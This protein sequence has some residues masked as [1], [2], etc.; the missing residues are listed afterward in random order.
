MTLALAP[1][2]SS[3]VKQTDLATTIT[4]LFSKLDDRF[5]KLYDKFMES[6]KN[7][8]AAITDQDTKFDEK[9]EKQLQPLSLQIK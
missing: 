2:D 6:V 7:I 9:I 1:S 5:C 4:D 8:T 3:Y